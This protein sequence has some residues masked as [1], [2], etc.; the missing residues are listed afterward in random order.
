MIEA[1]ALDSKITTSLYVLE[2]R[3]GK[4]GYR[5]NVVSNRLE[6]LVIHFSC[7]TADEDSTFNVR[8]AFFHFV[9]VPHMAMYQ[10]KASFLTESEPVLE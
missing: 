3:T 2:L 9:I 7:L 8:E 10:S 4:F 6:G 5:R 1:C